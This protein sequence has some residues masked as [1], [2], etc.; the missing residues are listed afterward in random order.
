[1][2]TLLVVLVCMKMRGDNDF[3]MLQHKGE[4]VSMQTVGAL[5]AE[6]RCHFND[7]HELFNIG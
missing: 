7:C 1:M 6:L 2:P 5:F 4:V 3:K